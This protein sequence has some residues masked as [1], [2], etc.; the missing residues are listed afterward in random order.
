MALRE[1]PELIISDLGLPVIDGLT[2]GPCLRAKLPKTTLI[3]LS[4]YANDETRQ[5]AHAAGFT[6][7]VVKPVRFDELLDAIGA[8]QLPN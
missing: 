8:A 6:G 1:R 4:G 3:A 7:Y 2:L 5:R